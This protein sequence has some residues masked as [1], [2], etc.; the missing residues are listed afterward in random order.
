MD[1]GDEGEARS[2][3]DTAVAITAVR[4]RLARAGTATCIECDAAIPQG[5]R[6]AYRAATRCVDCEE[7]LERER[8]QWKR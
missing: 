1:F 4:G 7:R 2:A 6:D 8:K 3:H 5:R